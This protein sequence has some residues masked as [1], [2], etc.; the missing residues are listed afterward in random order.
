MQAQKKIVITFQTMHQDEAN[1]QNISSGLLTNSKTSRVDGNALCA[2]VGFVY[3]NKPISQ[4][5]HII[6]EAVKWQENNNWLKKI[7]STKYFKR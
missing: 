7:L 4:L 5:K 2:I 3:S 1:E 6:P